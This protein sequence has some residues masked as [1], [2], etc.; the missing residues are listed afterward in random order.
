M[1]QKNYRE[2][3]EKN[4]FRL[5]MAK[6]N[7]LHSLFERRAGKDQTRALRK[8]IERIQKAIGSG[9]ERKNLQKY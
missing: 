8:E 7:E 1:E 9:K 3:P 4:L 6:T 5:L 2:V